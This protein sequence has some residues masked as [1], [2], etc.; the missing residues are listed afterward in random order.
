M[1]SIHWQRLAVATETQLA[2]VRNT[3]SLAQATESARVGCT[4]QLALAIR[5]LA[6]VQKN[7]TNGTEN[8]PADAGE[9]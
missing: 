1:Y 8:K 6:R 9:M 3:P 7:S 2:R 5:T 4:G